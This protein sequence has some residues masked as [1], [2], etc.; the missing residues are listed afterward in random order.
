MTLRA[1]WGVSGEKRQSW[2]ATPLQRFGPADA[3][4][5]HSGGLISV[6]SRVGCGCL[7]LVQYALYLR[8]CRGG[9]DQQLEVGVGIE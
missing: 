7:D 3:R 8:V 5:P 1:P 9:F 4:Q 2:G 6:R